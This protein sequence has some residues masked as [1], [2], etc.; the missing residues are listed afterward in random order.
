MVRQW[1]S[2]VT[3]VNVPIYTMREQWL[4]PQA[5]EGCDLL[6]V[7]HCNAPL[8]SRSPIIASI[9]DLIQIMDQGYRR[10]IKSW[11]YARPML[12]LVA[13]RAEHIVTL[14]EYSRTQIVER[15]RVPSNKVT[16]IYCGVSADFHPM[17][18]DAA[19]GSVSEQLGIREPY[20]LYVGSLKPHK[21]VSSLLK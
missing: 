8:L 20:I 2:R 13:R 9:L 3:V 19:F 18:R 10:S 15:L 16:A 5:A 21:N 4:I 11:L 1:C 17:E 12:N 14:S 7:P 6:H